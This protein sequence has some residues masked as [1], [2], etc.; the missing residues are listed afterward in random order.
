MDTNQINQMLYSSAISIGAYGFYKFVQN[1]YH[2]YY[3]KSECHQQ[4]L[5]ITIV[6]K[7]KEE[8]EEKK[9]EIEMTKTET[10]IEKK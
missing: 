6:E 7:D 10:N 5:E 8:K 1:L 2:K 4:T 9:I 3:V